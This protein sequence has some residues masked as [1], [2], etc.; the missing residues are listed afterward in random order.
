MNEN[1]QGDLQLLRGCLPGDLSR[2]RGHARLVHG[3]NE[4]GVIG[5]GEL[6]VQ[7]RAR[8]VHGGDALQGQLERFKRGKKLA[9]VQACRVSGAGLDRDERRAQAFER[10]AGDV[11]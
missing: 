1:A 4:R 3:C 6:G 7:R 9:R 2:W 8:A 5:R 10:P 11:D